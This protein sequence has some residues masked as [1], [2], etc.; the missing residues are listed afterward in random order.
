MSKVQRVNNSVIHLLGL[1]G[2]P[3]TLHRDMVTSSAY[4][5][6]EKWSLAEGVR[7]ATP[8]LEGRSH[9]QYTGHYLKRSSKRNMSVGKILL[10][11]SNPQYV[12]RVMLQKRISDSYN[13]IQMGGGSAATPGSVSVGGFKITTIQFLAPHVVLDILETSARDP[14]SASATVFGADVGESCSRLMSH[15]FWLSCASEE[16]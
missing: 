4:S 9:Q 8:V 2:S 13:K 6:V 11:Q 7:M 10:V 12:R 1:K 5:T 16:S 14:R 3:S 15:S